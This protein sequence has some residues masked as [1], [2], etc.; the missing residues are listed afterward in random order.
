[1][2]FDAFV[3]FQS[4]VSVDNVAVAIKSEGDPID[5]VAQAALAPPAND[6]FALHAPHLAPIASHVFLTPWQIQYLNLN[7]KE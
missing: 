6:I 2:S 3:A 5:D 1:L 4:Q 7:V